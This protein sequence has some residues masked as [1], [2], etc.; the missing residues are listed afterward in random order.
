LATV[1]PPLLSADLAEV[2]QATPNI[3]PQ[4]R[5]TRLFITGGTGFFGLWLLESLA[6]ANRELGLNAEA[7]VLSRDPAAFARRMPH[8][9]SLENVLWVRGSAVNFTVG[10][11]AAELKC[12]SKDLKFDAVIHLTTEA[13]NERTLAD[14]KAAV[15]VI[16][17]STRQALDFSKAVG[18]RRFLFTSSGSVYGRQPQDLAN[19]SEDWPNTADA[20]DKNSAYAI[21]GSAKRVAEELCVAC[22]GEGIVE[23]VIARCFAF[24]GPGLPANGKFAL[25]N[26]VDDALAGRDIVVKGDGTPVRSYLYAGDLTAWL[27]TLLVRG[28]AGRAYN[29]GSERAIT[30]RETAETVQREIAPLSRVRILTPIVSG[31]PTHRYVPST[32]RARAELGLTERVDL[33]SAIRRTA[34]WSRGE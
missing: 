28:A 17:G 15:E 22:A 31:A 18:A 7:T 29:V 12:R 10:S 3:W 26:F 27:W 23:A 33:Q 30:I 11:I 6:A 21:S 4:L 5:G 32:A 34:R 16:A 24:S 9:A 19:V 20:S 13:D 8:V 1:N 2:L 14:P 25:G